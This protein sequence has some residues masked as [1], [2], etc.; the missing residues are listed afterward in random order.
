LTIT[1]IDWVNLRERR[2]W[3][4]KVKKKGRKY[5]GGACCLSNGSERRGR[6]EVKRGTV[7]IEY[8]RFKEE[9]MEKEGRINKDIR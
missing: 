4:S 9:R 6:I 8:K 2:R 5:K 3:G 7:M 1:Y